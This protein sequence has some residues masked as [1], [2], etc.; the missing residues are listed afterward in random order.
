MLANTRKLIQKISLL[1]LLFFLGTIYASAQEIQE[2][3][4][5]QIKSLMDKK[6]P[7]IAGERENLPHCEHLYI[8][9]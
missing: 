5:C 9:F 1:L 4:M 8:I 6:E 2:S 3:D 7:R